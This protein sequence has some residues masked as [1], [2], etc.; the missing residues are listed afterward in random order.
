MKFDTETIPAEEFSGVMVGDVYPAMGGAGATN[1][2][3]VVCVNERTAH[4]LGIDRQGR[5]VSTTSYG[6]HTFSRREKIGF[7]ED[8][9]NL[10]LKITRM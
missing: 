4:A 5:I 3:V 8:M 1:A 9:Q 10:S 6:I 7:C 2:F